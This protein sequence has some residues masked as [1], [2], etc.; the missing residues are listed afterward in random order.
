MAADVVTTV[1]EL[2]ESRVRVQAEVP[3]AEVERRVAQ[4]AKRLGRNIRVPGFRAGKAPPPV[5]V[6]RMGRDAV[7]D[8]AVRESIGT[9]YTAAIDAARIAPVGE[10]Q[11]D[12]GDLPSQG[13]PLRFSIEIGVRP[14]AELGDY[15]G[16]EVGKRDPQVDDEALNAEIDRLR[17]RA[18]RLDT[19][20]RTAADGD[21]VIMDYVGT[22]DGTPFA[23]GEGRDQMVELGSG[24]LVP[25][26]EEQLQ[27]AAAG[28]ERTVTVTFPDDYGAEELA[29]REAEFAVTVK[30]I[31]AKE[32]PEVDDDLAAEAGFDTLDELREDI[33]ERLSEAETARI[34]AEFREAALDSA[35][36]NAKVN[37]PDALVEARAREQ[38]DQMLHSLAHQGISR[39][40][41]L[42][43]AG[44]EEDEIVERAKPEAE[45]GLRR[46]AVLAAI[47]EAEGIEPT[48][49]E[50]LEA[51]EQAA[52]DGPGRTSPKKLLER[53]KSSGRVDALKEDLAQRKALDLVADAAKPI[54]VEQAQARE[55][56]WTPGHEE[57][58][59]SSG[60][61]W[62]P[63]R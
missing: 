27:G 51:V 59:G 5:I 53:L 3:A 60:Q 48:D 12:L 13:E 9:W 33:R 8:E 43:I 23:G 15:K 31:K 29:G 46:E 54:T 20:D 42:R 22:L 17:E 11:L 38:W 35:V 62:T 56:L 19:V 21:F 6:Q 25:G 28:D 57:T 40:A 47:I 63:S 16:V 45:Q 7:L 30:E 1:T 24:R 10:P 41:Y 32:L 18:A 49:D 36:K 37:I 55:K 26:F 58:S 44:Q 39:D 50:V 14:K 61:L 52:G 4:A 2:P 34:E